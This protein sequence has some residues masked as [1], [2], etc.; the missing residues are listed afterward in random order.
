M[1]KAIIIGV[2]TISESH[3]FL[4]EIEELKNLCL[5]CDIEVIDVI[6]Q[7]LNDI[8]SSTYVG[9][10]KIEEIKIAINSL[11][12]ETLVFNDELTPSQINNLQEALEIAIYDRT[13]IILEIFKRRA[14]TKEALMQ[15]EIATLKYSL[16]RLMGLRQ[17]LSRQRGAGGGFAHGRG[18]GE[19][20]LE[21]DRRITN[22]RI[23]ALK[24]ELEA[25]TILRKQQRKT[26]KTNNMH[27]VCLVGYTNS[28]KSST[29][30]ALLNHSKGIKKEVFQKDMLFAT[31]ETSTR[32]IQTE[33][34]FRFL[35]TD[36][37]GF[38]NKLPH[39]L[40]EAFKSTL[41]EITEADLIVHVVDAT[42]SNYKLQI[43]TTEQVLQSIGV[44]NI[45]TIYAFNKIDL[46]DEYLYIQPQYI[47]AIRISATTDKNIDKLIEMIQK[48]LERDFIEI[49]LSIPYKEQEIIEFLK[50][51]GYVKAIN[52]LE[53]RIEVLGKLPQRLLSKV[54]KYK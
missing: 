11:D 9:K 23:V 25:A 15:V 8:N 53:T 41:E 50:D 48:E 28:G 34:N 18:A 12:A 36:T 24:K 3:I 26:R 10:G 1:E 17:G 22:D 39:H 45:P 38:V 20:K 5:A 21:L 54:E 31:L 6:T 52:Y 19:T 44:L 42:N 47:K 7:N 43:E 4:D 30:N 27:T 49:T 2:N 46:L 13:F 40:V 29:L 33:T 37:V 32:A 14:K 16:P 51:N 35:V